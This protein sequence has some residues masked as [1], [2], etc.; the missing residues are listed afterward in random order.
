[1]TRH[2]AKLFEMLWYAAMGLFLG[3]QAGTVL[4]VVEAFDSA[5][6][7]DAKPGLSPYNDPRFA[8][9][10]NEVVAGF[11][12]QNMFKNAGVAILI[13]VGIAL[14]SSIA[15]TMTVW[16]SGHATT[17]SMLL[18]RVRFVGLL[19][20]VGLM[21]YGTKQMQVMNESWP[22]LYELGAEQATL[23]VRRKSFDIA[24]DLSERVV[25]LA[26]FMGALALAIS[27]WCRRPADEVKPHSK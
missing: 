6:K 10:A 22:T 13:L 12:A 27:P 9:T 26:W 14:L 5:R 24:H 17:G 3:L 8:E 23:D 4:A 19:A 18:S 1:M 2:A 25:R 21:L 16:L 11:M 7:V 20:C 15:Y